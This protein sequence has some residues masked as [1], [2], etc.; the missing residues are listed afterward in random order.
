MTQTWN[1][2]LFAHWRTDANLLRDKIPPHFELD[3]FA[4]EAWISIVPFY[5][6]NV[7]FRHAP[8]VSRFAELNVRTYVTLDD[9]PGVYFFSLDT[10]SWLAVRTARLWL[11][12]PYYSA[13]MARICRAGRIAFRSD[14]TDGSTRFIGTYAPTGPAF[15]PVRG[16]LDYFLTER[17]CF[18]HDTRRGR[19]Y[20]LEIHHPQWQLH[21]AEAEV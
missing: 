19:P 17:Y 18:Y 4:G 7:S 16:S 10:A 1:D 13:A 21:S 2:L 3:L 15:S 11:N 14:R 5:M 8:W 20:R 6:T 12:L 9:R